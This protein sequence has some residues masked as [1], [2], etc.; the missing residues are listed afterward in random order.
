MRSEG[1]SFNSGGQGVE[2]CSRRVVSAFAT[3]RNRSQVER[4]EGFG[5]KH[6]VCEIGSFLRSHIGIGVWRVVFLA[7]WMWL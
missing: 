5:W 2:P 3:V 7:C 1:F 4:Y 6:D